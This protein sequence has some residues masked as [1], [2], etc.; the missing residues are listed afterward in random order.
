MIGRDRWMS[1]VGC[2]SVV[3]TGGCAMDMADALGEGSDAVVDGT[4][5]A[6]APS[7]NVQALGSFTHFLP[8]RGN[9]GAAST[10][11]QLG[12]GMITAMRLRT[13]GLVTAISVDLYQPSNPNNTYSASDPRLTRGPVGGTNGAAQ[14]LQQCASGYAAVGLHGRADEAV[15]AVGLLCAPIDTAT[16]RPR[17]DQV[18]STG[19]W[20]GSGGKA[21]RDACGEGKW[22]TAIDVGVGSWGSAQVVRS[23][24]GR[25][26]NAR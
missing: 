12:S 15:D 23:V 7:V 5:H 17:T 16:G 21:F 2:L 8:I 14:P 24:V 13:T 26:S 22:L 9:S 1:I 4:E 20:G 10:R 18:V 11:P 3:L 25:C 19:A 6:D